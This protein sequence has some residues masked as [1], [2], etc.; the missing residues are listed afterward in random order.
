MGN[1]LRETLE[2]IVYDDAYNEG[3]FMFSDNK[4]RW[5]FTT[6]ELVKK[7]DLILSKR[8][9]WMDEFAKEVKK[10][11]ATKKLVAT[12]DIGTGKVINHPAE[13][14]YTIGEICG[15]GIDDLLAHLKE[16]E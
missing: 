10:L 8:Q 2:K 9:E 11:P 3:A 15:K 13:V 1:S 14:E 5:C 7:V 6:E 16:Q 12:I 4:M